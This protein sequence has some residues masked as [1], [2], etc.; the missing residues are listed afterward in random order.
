MRNNNLL[1][2]LPARR[3]R[4]CNISLVWPA[5]SVYLTTPRSSSDR[6]YASRYQMYGAVARRAAMG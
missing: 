1:F 4:R 3:I 6:M 2:E 5:P